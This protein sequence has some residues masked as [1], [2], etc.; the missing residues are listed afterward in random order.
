[1]YQASP[2]TVTE[3]GREKEKEEATADRARQNMSF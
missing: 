2:E 3:V 1:M